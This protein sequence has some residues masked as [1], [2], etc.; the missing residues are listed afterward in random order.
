MQMI[1]I[2]R[3]RF[4]ELLELQ[5]GM[6]PFSFSCSPDRKVWPTPGRGLTQDEDRTYLQGVY[7]ELDQIVDIV[8]RE[9]DGAGRFYLSVEG[10]FLNHDD[11]QIAKFR[12]VD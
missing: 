4:L 9:R 3:K 2:S 7:S 1:P 6:K 12:F 11:R 10:V 8:A 5:I